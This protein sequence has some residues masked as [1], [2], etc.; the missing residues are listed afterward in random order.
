[1]EIA[2]PTTLELA[3]PLEPRH[4]LE[5]KSNDDVQDRKQIKTRLQETDFPSV[6]LQKDQ[7][8]I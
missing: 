1:M 6:C 2:L 4:P 5:C 3:E 7:I 8:S